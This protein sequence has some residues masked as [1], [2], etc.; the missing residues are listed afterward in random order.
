MEEVSAGGKPRRGARG[1]FCKPSTVGEVVI[2]EQ[3]KGE[4][5]NLCSRLRPF[6]GG[7]GRTVFLTH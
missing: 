4:S 3:E 6:V 2:T 7:A 5:R 1:R